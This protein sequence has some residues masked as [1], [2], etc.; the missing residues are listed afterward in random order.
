MTNTELLLKAIITLVNVHMAMK[1]AQIS[2]SVNPLIINSIERLYLHLMDK[3][4]Q[5]SPADFAEL[6]KNQQSPEEF[7]TQKKDVKMD[8]SCLMDILQ[9]FDVKDISFDKN[10]ENDELDISVKLV[11]K[12]PEVASKDDETIEAQPAESIP[13]SVV[14][15]DKVS[16][17]I[18][19]MN[20]I[21]SRLREMEGTVESFLSEEQ[22]EML[23]KLMGEVIQWLETENI[24][25]PV[26]EK[27]CG[28]LQRLIED[29]IKLG[30]F[31]EASPIIE[32]FN[33]ISSG[34]LKKDEKVRKVS[35]NVLKNLASDENI[36]ILIHE[37][38]INQKKKNSEACQ[39]LFGFGDII[40]QKMLDGVMNANES[41]E[42]IR[43][44]HIIQELGEKAIPAIKESITM[45]APWYYLRNM[46]Y[47]LGRIGNES[48][49]ELLR[50]L[51][52]HKD[53]R[54]RTE[55]FKSIGQTG[56]KKRGS[57]LLSVMPQVDQELKLD[58]IALLG[59]IKYAESIPQLLEMLSKK[60]SISR[61][62]QITMQEKIC[63]ALGAIGSSEAEPAL[64]EIAD[65]KSF[66]GMGGYPE[67]VKVA[68][69]R[70]LKLIKKL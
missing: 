66:L 13:V 11:A 4:R 27:I 69:R 16:E 21:L 9:G 39:I 65:S 6:E 50:L 54:V 7:L 45:N 28:D 5:D 61:E 34:A 22:R 10:P 53:K 59:K 14:S 3:L 12:S 8:V 36:N 48:S 23:K 15:E 60:S 40:M 46:A 2:P 49:A 67:E 38:D 35:M 58:I 57:L 41:K 64:T 18:A 63:N 62:E 24:V 19:E 20:Q 32:I 25:T 68:A 30:L 55:A 47:I 51:L 29:F 17:C 42:R 52:L 44:I 26:Y 1:D 37:I 31:T 56:G 43:I 33:K 70:A